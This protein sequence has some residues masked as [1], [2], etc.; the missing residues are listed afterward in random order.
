MT[1]KTEKLS[2]AGRMYAFV[3]DHWGEVYTTLHVLSGLINGGASDKTPNAAK[4]ILNTVLNQYG[5]TGNPYDEVNFKKMI[6]ALSASERNYLFLQLGYNFPVEHKNAWVRKNARNSLEEFR[7]IL[8]AMIKPAVTQERKIHTNTKNG[9]KTI[10]TEETEVFEVSPSDISPAVEYL[11]SIA[12][13]VK[14]Q[15][16]KE[17]RSLGKKMSELTDDERDTCRLKACEAMRRIMSLQGSPH[18]PAE[19]EKSFAAKIANILSNA[20]PA[21]Y[22]KLKWGAKFSQRLAQTGWFAT[23]EGAPIILDWLN[24][25]DLN[26]LRYGTYLNDRVTR[27]QADN[28]LMPEVWTWRE[29][30]RK[31]YHLPRNLFKKL[32]KGLMP[33]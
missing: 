29:A 10:S 14:S 24:K 3:K 23:K 1:E 2:I 17:V 16:L 25:N 31:L 6:Q 20:G 5:G 8:C 7:V 12:D 18:T 32:W 13:G 30:G 11:K 22:E 28:R 33:F 21:G 19:D 27:I 26:I 9:D 15:F 4:D